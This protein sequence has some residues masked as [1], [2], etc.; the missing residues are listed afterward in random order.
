MAPLQAQSYELSGQVID[1][2]TKE[3]LAFVNIIIN[4]NGTTGTSTDI[5][6]NFTISS[7][8]K[9]EILTLSYIGYTLKNLQIQDETSIIIELEP[10]DFI[11]N[12]ITVVAGENPAH[13]II[14]EA[15]KNR[16][17]NNPE[18]IHSFKYKSYN[19]FIADTEFDST[20]F[21]KNQIKGRNTKRDELIKSRVDSV[22]LAFDDYH[23]LIM[24]SVTERIFMRPD[25]SQETVLASRV[26]GL[27]NP[28]ITA[29]ATDI[30]PFSFYRSHIPLLDKAFINP[31]SKGSTQLYQFRLEE[32]TIFR[33]L[34]TIFII[35]FQPRKGKNFEAL[36]G[37]L[38][39]NTNRYAVQNVIAE[40]ATT[41]KAHLKIEQ[42]YGF[43]QDQWFPSQLNFEVDWFGFPFP[44]TDMH[45]SGKSY[46]KDIEIE[47]DIRSK[48]FGID[49]VVIPPEAGKKASDFWTT[50]RINPLTPKEVRS[51]QYVDSLGAELPLD[52]MATLAENFIINYQIRFGKVALDVPGLLNNNN[53]EGTRIG[54][55]MHTWDN[56][57]KYIIAGG[58]V[59]YGLKDKAWKWGADVRFRNPDS[60]FEP[61]LQLEYF[62][63]LRESG[64]IYPPDYPVTYIPSPAVFQ[65]GFQAAR[66]DSIQRYKATFG[67]RPF[68]Y[69]QL[70]LGGSFTQQKTLSHE[71]Y[72]QPQN[73]FQYAALHM[74]VRYA[75]RE[76]NIKLGNWRVRYD[77]PFPVLNVFYTKSL[78]NMLDTDIDFHRLILAFEGNFRL[79]RLG[80]TFIWLEGGL[81]SGDVPYPL[82]FNGNG[83][84]SG[85]EPFFIP[86]TFQTMGLYEFTGNRFANLFV[87][88]NFGTLLL[89]TEKFRPDFII[90]QGVGFG[91]LSGNDDFQSLNK[92]YLESGLALDNLI[93]INVMNMGYLGLGAGVFYRYGHYHLPKEI[94]NYA[95]KLRLGFGF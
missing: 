47:P 63:D 82:L 43:V 42:Q 83:S 65:R 23:T 91:T 14:R 25:K 5:D 66:M 56:L 21:L 30:Q 73:Q 40:P 75:F 85:G 28:T 53:Y 88:H 32:D 64:L 39:I 45:L 26:S 8:Q 93:R 9:I 86:N 78:P 22:Q 79:K 67:I 20:L 36:K 95:F 80:E 89:R 38:Y 13:R 48:D 35:S 71:E 6:G 15:V 11:L 87:Y 74:N 52:F 50:E 37:L 2:K 1:A 31:I 33:Q 70:Q 18:K 69:A 54:I 24:E 46:F 94:N 72:E 68:R 3:N 84:Q 90:A 27:T 61:E 58:Y 59:S 12:E 60:R 51:Y 17:I 16:N 29:L 62:N 41:G 76:Q 10:E 55:G 81:V 34:D 4:G 19:K 44:S 57:Y 92:G 49:E 7:E 77:N